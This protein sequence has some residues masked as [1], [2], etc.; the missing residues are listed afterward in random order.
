MG[1]YRRARNVAVFGTALQTVLVIVM[2]IMAIWTGS[3]AA[4]LAFVLMAV[5]V[6]VWVMTAVLFYSH[7]L[8]QREAKEL[9][10]LGRQPG[11]AGTVFEGE[12]LDAHRYAEARVAFMYRWAAP[13]FTIVLAAAF[14][15][16]P[17]AIFRSWYPI[18]YVVEPWLRLRPLVNAAQASMFVI[19]A[20]AS[21]FLFSA[22]TLGMS[23][24]AVWRPLRAP[25][26]Y[27]LLSVLAAGGVLGSFVGVWLDAMGVDTWVAKG[28]LVV[29]HLLVL[30]L[31]V[32]LLLSYF[33]PR[34]PGREERLAY[35]SWLIGLLANPR[36]IGHA[37]AETLNY[38]F[39]F[40][41]S[42]TWFV[43]LLSRTI[44][45][46]VIAG[47]AIMVLASSIVIVDEGHRCVVAHFGEIDPA[48]SA[49]APGLHLKWPWPIDSARYVDMR[50]R[51]LPFGVGDR[52]E[53]RAD[54]VKGGTFDGRELALWTIEHGAYVEK[55]FLLA[56]PRRSTAARS[57]GQVEVPAVNIIRMVGEIY[58]RIDDPV[59]FTTRYVDV[60]AVLGQLVHR[61]MIR[62]CSSA[63]LFEPSPYDDPDQGEAI[64]TFGRQAMAERLEANIRQAVADRDG[65]GVEILD[66][67]LRMVHPPPSAADAFEE[68]LS[69]RLGQA[70]QRYQ[71]LGEAN[72]IHYELAARPGAAQELAIALEQARML[73][74]LADAQRQSGDVLAKIE[75]AQKAIR[76]DI[77]DLTED[78]RLERLLGKLEGDTATVTT[79][80]LDVLAT[81]AE[82]LQRIRDAIETGQPVDLVAEAAQAAAHA[83]ALFK[84]DAT[85]QP[86]SLVSRAWTERW[87]LELSER[88]R[89][90]SFAAEV[91]AFRA[92]PR[93]YMLDRYLDIWDEVLPRM[94]KYVIG[95]DPQRLEPWLNLESGQAFHEQVQFRARGSE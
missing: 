24:Q 78:R 37:V 29:L 38:Q 58:Y 39:G 79:E 53:H 27:L 80:L 28:I 25:A 11:A 95:I 82:R 55:D 18:R 22:Y 89:S 65:I 54:I 43:R 15:F 63:T 9:E 19:L 49:L 6:A 5:G 46:L 75:D 88:G 20:G 3:M 86:A 51:H 45:P 30:E 35:D 12:Q 1:E 91:A 40:D 71:A 34:V 84:D 74:G 17:A 8:Q 59:A 60:E 14:Y 73:A 16:I 70:V 69:A 13:I 36:R 32:S 85:G 4:W 10:D 67:T 92:S 61:E 94:P 23:R 90:R 56:A 57:E 62:T 2:L 87:Q 41:V 66:L 77:N 50:V 44:G 21:G 26:G 42:R 33:R 48:R 72:S 68:V 7:L 64:M 52:R 47:A 31:V 83:Q 93:A 81:A 76:N